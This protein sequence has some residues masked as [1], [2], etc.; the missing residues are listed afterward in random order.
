M[1]QQ[2]QTAVAPP[3]RSRM[4]P[5]I[6]EVR[7]GK[8]LGRLKGNGSGRYVWHACISCGK[9]RW[10]LIN[11][12]MP[13]S[14]RCRPCSNR[15]NRRGS[16]RRYDG[17]G[18]ILVRLEADDFFLPMAT[19]GNYILEHRLLMAKHLKRRLFPWEIIHHR[20]GITDDNR[21]DNLQLLPGIHYHTGVGLAKRYIRK[22]ER[23]IRL[24]STRNQELQNHV[25]L[26]SGGAK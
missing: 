9:R 25:A 1:A 15:K 26:L 18:Y 22:L 7:T 23:Q 3:G 14:M 10:V 13:D 21:L 12:A 8:Q 6:G 5:Q 19:S 20:N 17:H 24:L 11:H 16:D 2:T 4:E